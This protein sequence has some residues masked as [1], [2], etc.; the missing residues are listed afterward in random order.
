MGISDIWNTNHGSTSLQLRLSYAMLIL[1]TISP[2][3]NETNIF[4]NWEIHASTWS[5]VLEKHSYLK[6]IYDLDF[7][8]G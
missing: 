6:T 2:Q 5:A 1:K 7:T 3:I 8:Y 4:M